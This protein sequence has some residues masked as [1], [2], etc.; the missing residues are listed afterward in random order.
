MTQGEQRR[1]QPPAGG[2]DWQRDV[3][4]ELGGGAGGNGRARTGTGDGS[5]APPVR[6]GEPTLRL[7]HPAPSRPP[8]TTATAAEAAGG[9]VTRPARR[10]GTT[11]TSAAPRP[12][13]PCPVPGPPTSRHRSGPRR[14]PSP[15]VTPASPRPPRPTPPPPS[16]PV[17]SSP[18]DAPCTATP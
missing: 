12:R 5:G 4:R 16:I 3:L 18:W 13:S 2:G 1:E 14:P 11:A 8:V 6:P 17:S 9:E 7:V 10:A 15:P